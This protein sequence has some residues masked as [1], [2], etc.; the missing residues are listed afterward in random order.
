LFF[1]ASLAFAG[2]GK[3]EEPFVKIQHTGLVGKQGTVSG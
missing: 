3:G 2:T 1:N